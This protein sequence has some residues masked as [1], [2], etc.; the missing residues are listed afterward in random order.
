M[1]VE[2]VVTFAPGNAYASAPPPLEVV[3]GVFLSLGPRLMISAARLQRIAGSDLS[4]VDEL[5]DGPR[6]VLSMH[7]IECIQTAALAE[8]LFGENGAVS[9][10]HQEHFGLP[11]R[12]RRPLEM[13][14]SSEG[15]RAAKAHLSGFALS[16][17]N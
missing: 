4:G 12:G 2:E 10:W 15:I 5:A 17:P 3:L 11:C 14:E 8:R 1:Q 7:L 6:A 9:W 13:L 16:Q